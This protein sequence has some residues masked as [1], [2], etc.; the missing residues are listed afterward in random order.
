M[1]ERLRQWAPSGFGFGRAK[2]RYHV[3]P[4]VGGVG[5]GVC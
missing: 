5:K 1:A 2:C 4:V 3:S